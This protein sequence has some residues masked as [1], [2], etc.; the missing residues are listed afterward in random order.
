MEIKS[1][2]F[3][4][5]V[6]GTDDVVTDGIPQVAFVGRSNVGK[7]SVINS[8]CNNGGLA[9]T[10]KKPGKT[11]EINFFS[12]NKDELYIVDLPGYGYAKVGP[13][14]KEMLK[15]LIYWYVADA[16]VKPRVIVVVIDT[17]VGITRYDTE[18]IDLLKECG[19]NYV[20]AANKSDKLTQKGLA[21]QLKIIK[22]LA[23]GAPVIPC[24]TTKQNG[25]KQL[26]E[27]VFNE[28]V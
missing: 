25:T 10:G 20:I 18:M 11:T 22:P 19:Q 12:I 3:I 8:L 6:R 26:F 2:T 9:K 14:E 23:Q 15:K 17:K 7:S 27:K 5:G 16:G 21:D 28:N 13:K 24:T 4:K 1:A